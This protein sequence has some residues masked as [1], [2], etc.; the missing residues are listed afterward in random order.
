M[1]T[2]TYGL[3]TFGIDDATAVN[4]SLAATIAKHYAGR[5]ELGAAMLVSTLNELAQKC[6]AIVDGRSSGYRLA[7]HFAQDVFDV[8]VLHGMQLGVKRV[9]DALRQA[10]ATIVEDEATSQ[11]AYTLTAAGQ[12]ALRGLVS[13][14]DKRELC[15]DA[16]FTE[17]EQEADDAF[18]A[19]RD[20]VIEIR[21][22][23]SVSGNPETI[24]LD[25][26]WFAAS[27]I[28]AFGD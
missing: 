25:R 18:D 4:A 15:D 1:G 13:T 20:A 28:T 7:D 6:E 26:A 19:G 2:S 27:P 14:T 16:Y 8:L 10:G 9:D 11:N 21:A 24:T 5:E 12:A 23:H 17:A 3:D 22:M